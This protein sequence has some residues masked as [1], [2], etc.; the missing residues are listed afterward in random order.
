MWKIAHEKNKI[1]IHIEITILPH[2]IVDKSTNDMTHLR[3]TWTKVGRNV[4]FIENTLFKSKKELFL[5]D[6]RYKQNVINIF[7]KKNVR[8][9][10]VQQYMPQMM[11]MS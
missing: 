4:L 11:Q 7:S 6:S 10:D 1:S 9:G 8:N 3:R 2:T 5:A